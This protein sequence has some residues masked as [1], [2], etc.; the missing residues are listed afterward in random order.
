LEKEDK[1][2]GVRDVSSETGSLGTSLA[3]VDKQQEDHVRTK[4]VKQFAILR[5]D[6]RIQLTANVDLSKRVNDRR[7]HHDHRTYIID[8]IPTLSTGGKPRYSLISCGYSR[9]KYQLTMTASKA[10]IPTPI[11][12][13]PVRGIVRPRFSAKMTGNA[14]NTVLYVSIV[15]P[16][17]TEPAGSV[18]GF[19][20]HPKRW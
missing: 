4:L 2:H 15:F 1:D 7:R 18:S 11:N 20:G 19:E 14:S 6:S 17:T 12:I 5:S 13:R 8:E 10:P 16:H 3:Y 9:K